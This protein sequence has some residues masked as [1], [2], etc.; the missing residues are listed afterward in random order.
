MT[1]FLRNLIQRHV[2]ANILMFLLI[3][4]GLLSLS[5]IRQEYLPTRESHAVQISVAHN[6]A[7]PKEIETSI[8]APIESAIRGI[9]GIK[10]I[11]ASA[12]EGSGELRLSLLENVDVQQLAN[13]IRNAVERIDTLPEEAEKPSI[14]IPAEIESVMTL[15]VYG[16]QPIFWLRKAAEKVRDDLITDVGLSKVRLFA[17][18]EQ[19]ITVEVKENVLREYNLSLEEIAGRI[20]H[21]SLNKSGGIIYNSRADIALRTNE[22]R[23]WANDFGDIAIKETGTGLSL[24]LSDIAELKDGFGNS[25]IEAWYN[26][27]PAIQ[28]DVYAVGDE[29]PELVEDLVKKHLEDTV[30]QNHSGISIDIF[31]NDAQSFRERASLLID[32]AIFGLILVLII[33]GLFLTPSLAFWVMAGIPIS[34]LGGCVLL[35]IFDIS[36]NMISLFAF[37][38]T[39]GVTVDDTVMVGEAY[40]ANIKKGMGRLDAAIQGVKEMG[41]PVLMATST[42]IIA[43]MPMFFVPG[44]MGVLFKQIPAVVISVLVVS[45]IESIFILSAHL[46]QEHNQSLWLKKLSYPQK[47]INEKLEHFTHNSFRRFIRLSFYNPSVT[48]ALAFSLLLITVA[49][50]AGGLVGFSFTPSIQADKVVAQATLPY[51]SPKSKSISIQEKLVT[52]AQAILREHGMQSPGI[53]SLIGARLDEGEI[54][55]GTLAGTHYVSVIM[56]LPPGDERTISGTQFAQKWQQKFGDIGGLE[57]L[58]FTGEKN[59][60]GGEPIRLEIFH[61][62][63]SIAQNAALRLGERMRLVAGLTSIDDGLRAGK[64]ELKL[65]LKKQGVLMGITAEELASQVRSRFHGVEALQIT[66]NGNSVKVM[67][68]LDKKERTQVASLENALLKAP[69]GNMVP[70]T[71]VADISKSQSTTG[72][73]RRD[74]KRIYPV[75]ADIMTG[76]SDDVVEDILENGIL[77]QLLA[78]YPGISINFAGEEEEDDEALTTLGSGLIIVLVIMYVL[79]AIQ[80]NSYVQPLLVLSV[81]PFAFI[82]AIW[83]HILLGYE[84]SIISVVGIIAMVG[85]IVNDSMVLMAAYNAFHNEGTIHPRAILKAACRRLQPILLTTLTTFFGLFPI[86][87]ETSEQA[88]FLIPMAISISFGLVFGTFIVLVLLPQLILLFGKKKS[89]AA[90]I[91]AIDVDKGLEK[92][93]YEKMPMGNR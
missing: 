23:E 30:V 6:G 82:G 35:P 39:I 72:L 32:N 8:L 56:A 85:V 22:R 75:T 89:E 31:E 18:R 55:E 86:M 34:L 74:G 58:T 54:E 87:L 88:Q 1:N 57:A 44:S 16:D 73:Y 37:I 25:P 20:Q 79:F 24:R 12:R 43:F 42:T 9:D 64:P 17:P 91:K 14:T 78:E 50:V 90:T 48:L 81:I 33:L 60:T 68:R 92:E 93:L 84:I 38:V 4:G 11:E 77:P 83:G 69:S 61:S 40:H 13:D 46:A 29:T 41:V 80:F 27:K 53:F 26:G 10:K 51:G 62:D 66:R 59:V 5:S 76:V 21:G 49:A 45:L 70:L 15:I 47:R 28:I 36:I 2:L 63:E 3:A 52:D 19:E 67:V 71:E 65:S 7:Q